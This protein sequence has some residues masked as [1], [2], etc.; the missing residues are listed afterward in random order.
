MQKEK[1]K[2]TISIIIPVY[3][4][5]NN[6]RPLY[7]EIVKATKNIDYDVELI[8]VSDGSRDG[9]VD[10]IKKL[11]SKINKI[12][13]VKLLEIKRN[14]GKTNALKK[15][16]KK[17]TGDL[18]LT[19]DGDLQ[20]DPQDI[21][22]FIE[23]YKETGADLIVGNRTNKYNGKNKNYIKYL[24]SRTI[25]LIA[26]FLSGKKVD[27]V[28]CGFKLMTKEVTDT[29]LLKSDYH[30]YIPILAHMEGFTITQLN[31]KQHPRHSG[32]SKYGKTGLKRFF[33]SI[34]DMLSIALVYK[35]KKEPFRFFGG[36]GLSLFVIGTL[37]FIYLVI[38][39]L[40]GTYIY[41]RPLFFVSILFMILGV[42]FLT[43]GFLAELIVM[44][45]K[46]DS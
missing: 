12:V 11:T 15:G 8:Y 7:D 41:G 4:E 38:K 18:I 19:I 30:R 13:L 5:K 26:K 14:K 32:K 46:K 10:E 16:F 25:N 37:I 33:N 21:V 27:D 22:R 42:N 2:E 34:I 35:F 40:G 45:N 20:D 36:M 6:I 31:I 23:K 1:L 44:N 9:T 29:I 43:L 28:N 24:S 17:A 39:W 3:N